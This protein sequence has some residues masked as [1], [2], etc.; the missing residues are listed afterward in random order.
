MK[1]WIVFAPLVL[2]AA[3]A[4]DASLQPM[5]VEQ[6]NGGTSDPCPESSGSAPHVVPAPSCEGKCCPSKPECYPQ[7]N[8]SP[9]S[10]AECLAMRD[11]TAKPR[12][13]FRQT[14]SVS[15]APPGF[16]LPQIADILATQSSLMSEACRTPGGTSGFIQLIDI[17][18]EHDTSRVGFARTSPDLAT[19]ARDGLCFVE[20]TYDDPAHRLTG[21]PTPANWPKGL[22][23]PMPLPWQVKVVTST[24]YKD[25]QGQFVD[26]DLSKD[27][28]A[29][30]ARF[31]DGGDLFGK[32]NGIYYFDEAAGYMHGFSP[33]VYIV[34]YSLDNK[35]YNAIP[36]REAELR[37]QLNDPAHPNCAGALLGDNPNLPQSCQGTSVNRL[38]GCPAGNCS[39]T[40][41]APASVKG[42]FLITELEQAYNPLGRTLCNLITG[43]GYPGWTT[44]SLCRDDPQ[45]NPADPEHG[46]PP[47]DWCA[48]TNSKGDGLCHDAWQSVSFAAFQAFPLQDA[49]CAA[50]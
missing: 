39:K 16:A 10:G 43:G 12:W 26:F 11:N 28:A 48:A 1:A 8:P 49:S 37:F 5:P 21:L 24:R 45:W 2:A 7:G 31:A 25:A 18:S 9:Y 4:C 30:L 27:R 34:N 40:E 42:Y 19:A 36:L 50:L 35:A 22:S 32:F 13:Q 15:T 20:G 29:I 23:P 17:D 44:P 3:G 41:L 47:G 14:L 46:I 33:V 6:R 38:W